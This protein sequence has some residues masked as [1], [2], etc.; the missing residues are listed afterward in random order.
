MDPPLEQSPTL[1]VFTLGARCES[2]R[3]RLLPARMHPVEDS[4]HQACLDATLAAGREAGCQLEVSSPL[5]L[6]LPADVR[7]QRQEGDDFGSRIERA[8]AE[9]FEE[10]GGPVLLVGSDVPEL[11]AA[12]LRQTMRALEEDPDRVV[13]GPSPDGGLYLLAAARPLDTALTEVRWQCRHTLRSLKRMLRC[14]GRPIV[15]LQP[16]LD[17]DHRADL[18]RW[19]TMAARQP[20]AAIWRVS[21]GRRLYEQLTQALKQ[22]VRSWVAAAFPVPYRYATSATSLRG[23]PDLSV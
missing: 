14:E 6:A 11:D 3:R 4:L 21:E 20:E 16:L 18:E 13:I 17:L 10:H 19:L 22:L 23:P 5:E 1:L 15:I 7:R 9:A 8:V 12:H 2:Q